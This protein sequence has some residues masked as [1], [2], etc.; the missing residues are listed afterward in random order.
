MLLP[1]RIPPE[2]AGHGISEACAVAAPRAQE[3]RQAASLL[4][5]ALPELGLASVASSKSAA[6]DLGC[7]RRIPTRVP[8]IPGMRAGHCGP[9]SHPWPSVPN[10]RSPDRG[11]PPGLSGPHPTALQRRAPRVACAVPRAGWQWSRATDWMM[12]LSL[13]SPRRRH[14]ADIESMSAPLRRPHDHEFEPGRGLLAHRPARRRRWVSS[15]SARAAARIGVGS[16]I[17][18]RCHL[19]R[20]P[21]PMSGSACRRGRARIHG[22]SPDRVHRGRVHRWRIPAP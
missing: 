2:T 12:I 1:F 18:E 11:L 19:P 7:E 20:P 16:I 15:V 22:R 6:P 17:V 8:A 21:C 9:R 4:C 14:P 5:V 3:R 13:S 10:D